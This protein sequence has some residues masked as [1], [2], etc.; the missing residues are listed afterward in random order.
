MTKYSLDLSEP[1]EKDLID[2][3]K[4]IA[5]QLSSSMSAYHMMEIFEEAMVSLSDSPQ[6]CPLIADERLSQ[7]GYRKL[8]AKNYIVFFSVD[9]KNRVV[10]VERILYARRDWLRYI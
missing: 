1:A 4:Y 6:K 5:S 10:N 7:L 3:V 9:E 8:I 2:I